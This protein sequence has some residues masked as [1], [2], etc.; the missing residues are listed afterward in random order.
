MANP[1]SEW[2]LS[3]LQVPLG[4][5]SSSVVLIDAL[6][7]GCWLQFSG[8][9]RFAAHTAGGC[10]RNKT[11]AQFV[12]PSIVVP[13][14]DSACGARVGGREARRVPPPDPSR[15]LSDSAGGRRDA[16]RPR[17][18]AEGLTYPTTGSVR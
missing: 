4:S 11:L 15:G 18:R 6:T 17:T 9:L 12:V 13:S 2:T 5:T 10:Q 1:M 14:I 16:S 8:C 7:P 3:T